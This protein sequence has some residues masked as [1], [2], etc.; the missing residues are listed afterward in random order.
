MLIAIGMACLLE[1]WQVWGDLMILLRCISL[2][3]E[4]AQS[5]QN[6]IKFTV[7][8]SASGAAQLDFTVIEFLNGSRM[9]EA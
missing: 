5:R 8:S 1:I 6:F 3:R 2:R 4:I 9:S 7:Y